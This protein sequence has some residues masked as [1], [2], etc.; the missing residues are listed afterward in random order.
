MYK[1]VPLVPEARQ[2]I[3]SA[4]EDFLRIFERAPRKDSDPV[5]LMK[6]IIGEEEIERQTVEAMHRSGMRPHLIYAYQKTGGLLLTRENES[7]ATTKD[8][9]DW[10]AAIEEYYSLKKNPPEPNPI[11]VLLEL[12]KEELDSCIICFGYVLEYGHA[13]DIDRIS[14]SSELFNADDYALICATKSMKTLRAIKALLNQNI[15]ADA[16]AL[17]RHLMENYLH[18]VYAIAR[19]DMLKHVVDAQVGL[20]LG[21]H[22]FARST[23]G[24]V[25]SRRIIRKKDGAEFLG[26]ISYHRMAESSPHVE[27]LELFD[28]AYSFLS[29]YTHP[30]FSGAALVLNEHGTLNPLSNELQSE[31][32]FYSVCFAAM[33]LNELRRLPLFSEDA[34][35][36]IFT[37]VKRVGAKAEV[38]IDLMIENG[39]SEKPLEVLRNRLIALTQEALVKHGFDNDAA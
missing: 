15:G 29:E 37:V 8:I 33:I 32:L 22:E 13:T 7:L 2:L 21:T 39:E 9:E 25:D 11:E 14:S 17:A 26:H 34:K 19:P 18:I 3:E 30:S 12:L 38:L 35:R 27:D 4:K 1:Q 36:D 20:K 5:F 16:L 28:Y 23:N 10:D 31:A 24:K 6:Y